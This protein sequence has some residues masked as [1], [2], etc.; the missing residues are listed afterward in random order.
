[1][2]QSPVESMISLILM[3]CISGVLLFIFN[4][5]FLGL[6]FVIIYVGAIAVLFLFII[7]ML[8]IKKTISSSNE[9][10]ALIVFSSVLVLI[11]A[12][13]SAYEL[14]FAE[15]TSNFLIYGEGLDN[16]YLVNESNQAAYDSLNNITVLGQSL[17][18]YYSLSFLLAGLVLLI[19]LVGAVVL[20]V[21][22]ST[23]KKNQLT[24]RQLSRTDLFL[25]HFKK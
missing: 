23:H 9:K 22:F 20:T 5:E 13:I 2:S 25:S 19:A 21:N 7:M 18:N 4:S 17:F 11:F 1:M 6:T 15:S 12:L 10:N 14:F 24:Y 3:F 8:N 16:K